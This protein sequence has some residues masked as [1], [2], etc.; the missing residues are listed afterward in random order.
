LY[1]SGELQYNNTEEQL[2]VAEIEQK[3]LGLQ[4]V[5]SETDRS[6][7]T[8]YEIHQFSIGDIAH[9]HSLS[10]GSVRNKISSINSFLK[11]HSRALYGAI[12]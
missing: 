10:E 12:G 11:K 9:F 6:I 3:R 7:Y 8:L 2:N 4:D 1:A 5:L